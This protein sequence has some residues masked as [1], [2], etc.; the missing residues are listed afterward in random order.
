MPRNTAET[1]S[2]EVAWGTEGL[3]SSA[4]HISDELC[5]LGIRIMEIA[6]SEVSNHIIA[7]YPVFIRLLS[8]SVMAKVLPQ[9]ASDLTTRRGVNTIFF[10]QSECDCRWRESYPLLIKEIE[11]KMIDSRHPRHHRRG[12]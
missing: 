8:K 12:H 7:S 6:S 2:K 4:V 9:S 1:P 3:L 10:L 11:N 5:W